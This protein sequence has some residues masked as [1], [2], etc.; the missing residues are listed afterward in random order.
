M[1]PPLPNQFLC[2]ML[3][4]KADGG[5]DKIPVD[6][7]G[8][9]VNAHNPA[10]WMDFETARA[11]AASLG[12]RFGVAFDLTATDPWFFID[13]DK[14]LDQES[15][16]WKPEAVAIFNAFPGAW[17]EVSSSGRGLH[18]LG[19]CDK[20]QLA[21]KRNK[22]AGWIEFYDRDRFVAFGGRGWSQIGGVTAEPDYTATLMQWV[23]Q[24]AVLGDLPVGVDPRWTGPTDDD[25]LIRRMLDSAPRGAGAVFGG[26][27]SAA[28]L[29]NANADVLARFY[30]SPNGAGFDHSSADSALMAH[31]AFW[32]GKD[33]PRMDRLF[34]RS[35]LMREKYALREDYRTSTIA[36]VTRLC[37]RVYD[38]PQR[39]VSPQADQGVES[40]REIYLTIPEQ[41]KHFEGCV[42]IR[43]MH[44]VLV[45]GG[46]ILK[47]EQFNASYGGHIFAMQPD[48]TGP[49]KKAFEAFTENRAYRFPQALRPCFR[50]DL[51][52][53]S[54]LPDL[55]VNTYYPPDVVVAPGDVTRFLDFLG[56][57]LP[58]ARDREILINYLAAV[59]QHPGVKFQWAPVLQGCEGNGKTLVF[60]TLG[61]AVGKQYTHSP[62]A[63]QLAE[64]FNG[65]IEGKVFILV[66]E[67][68]M[69][70]K[71]EMLDVLK[72]LV[73]N[74]DMEIRG[75]AQEKRMIEN[76][77]NWGFC[78]NHRDAV[79]KSK[80]D[81]RYAVFFTAQQE[82]DDLARDGMNGSYFPDL[83][84]WCREGGYAAIAH[85]L[86]TYP[87]ADDLN[88][89][90]NCHRAPHTSTTD[91]AI[92]ESRGAAEMEILEAAADNTRGFKGDWVSS[93]ALDA[94]LS[95]R[96]FKLTR[97]RVAA[98]M[99]DLGF[100][101]W[102]R[103][104][105]PILEEDRK[106]PIL[107]RKAGA[108][109]AIFEDYLTAQSYA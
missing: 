75:M 59:V 83:Y 18:I 10:N 7:Q 40:T 53:G 82:V 20:S 73:T 74:L 5:T 19:R 31:L 68:H 16:Q 37:Q 86:K 17:G 105:R 42:Y 85:Y 23:P 98:I 21:D 108:P 99:R 3:V 96:G 8:R 28:D 43:D 93:W 36:N 91:A 32:T 78:T 45:P 77:A 46:S 55:S 97:N 67:L 92:Q 11:A 58:N 62:R 100:I 80:N 72:P 9:A 88:P 41:I 39:E 30:P 34:R 47:P 84:K 57:L 49:T 79:L 90:T 26:K 71:R 25:E 38:V 56:K 22:W 4:P 35:G 104:P 60:S 87:I 1:I 50:P 54:I 64:K 52:P 109:V 63:E 65:Y 13:L 48:G 106:R 101:E 27:V 70:G 33:M 89:A 51:E 44:R 107:Y 12:D 61:Y 66:E 81:R 2:Y 69:Q 15:G 6:R 95:K 29:W 102:G 103:A 14:C 76:R 94:H 24:K